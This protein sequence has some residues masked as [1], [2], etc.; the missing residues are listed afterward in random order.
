[1]YSSKKIEK[2]CKGFKRN[3]YSYNID[4]R[5]RQDQSITNIILWNAYN[6]S[7]NE[8]ISG[9]N[10]FYKINRNQKGKWEGLLFCEK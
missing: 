3:Q 4:D 7:I 1:M 2:K 5:H 8:Y 6:R 9:Y 10:N